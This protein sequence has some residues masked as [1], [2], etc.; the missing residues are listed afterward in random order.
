MRRVLIF[1]TLAKSL[2]CS[3]LQTTSAQD[4]RDHV[5][6]AKEGAFPACVGCVVE[7]SLEL[8]VYTTTRHSA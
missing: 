5:E 4:V 6:I 1:S 3:N 7:E 8:G 2:V